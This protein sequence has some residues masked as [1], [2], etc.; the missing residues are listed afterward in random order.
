MN[1]KEKKSLASVLKSV[2]KPVGIGIFWGIC[3]LV[4]IMVVSHNNP[5]APDIHTENLKKFCACALL[6]LACVIFSV[7]YDR[8]FIIPR[9]LFQSRELIWKLAKND[10]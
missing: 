2:P 3:I 10:F 1:S 4:G 9:E 7:Y 5:L 6:L 8:M